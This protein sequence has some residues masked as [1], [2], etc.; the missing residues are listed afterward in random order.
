MRT[1][2]TRMYHRGYRLEDGLM[3]PEDAK[4]SECHLFGNN[5]SLV[6][7]SAAISFGRDLLY[8]Y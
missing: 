3:D 8:S 7:K 4:V 2:T 5:E 1:R 6:K